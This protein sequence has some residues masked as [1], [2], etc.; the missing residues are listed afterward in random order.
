MPCRGHQ[1]FTMAAVSE[2]VLTLE[3]PWTLTVM[4]PISFLN[5][6]FRSYLH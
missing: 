1:Y 5:N 6:A 2:T 4:K 3:S